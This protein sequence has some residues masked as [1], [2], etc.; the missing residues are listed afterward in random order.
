MCG[1]EASHNGDG[2]RLAVIERG[3]L[4]KLVEELVESRA[5]DRA[6]IHGLD[7]QRRDQITAGA[8][9][10]NELFRRCI[11][12]AFTSA[13]RRCARAFCWIICRGICRTW[14][15]AAR[16]PTRAGAASWT[17]AGAATGIARTP[18]TSPAVPEDVR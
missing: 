9:L 7:D 10:V 6:K 1:S 15:S 18:S 4:D 2:H 5:K 11:S 14:R 17:W 8:L 13:R 12:S 3:P 16:S